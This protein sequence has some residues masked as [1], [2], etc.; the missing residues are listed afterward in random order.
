MPTGSWTFR[1]F[2]PTY[3]TGNQTPQ[4]EWGLIRAEAVFN[5]QVTDTTL[6]GTIE[7][8]GPPPGGLNLNGT[9]WPGEGDEPVSVGIIGTGRP[10]TDT[11]GWDYRYVGYLIRNWP[12]GIDQ[13]PA[14]V[15]SV[16][17]MKT[18]NGRGQSPA[19]SLYS[20][21]AVKQPPVTWELSGSWTY[22]SFE[23][24]PEPVYPTPPQQQHLIWL[25]AAFKLETPTS[26]TGLEGTLE[27][28]G[29]GLDLKGTVRWPERVDSKTVFNIVGTGRPRTDTASWEYHY[30]GLQT[31]RWPKP[32]DASKTDQVPT[33]VGSV[34]RVHGEGAP[35]GYVAPFI[36]VKK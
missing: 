8:P 20:F 36:A 35:A 26:P 11:A 34:I 31:P 24:K 12:N 2:N 21:I 13:R 30:H 10:D 7:W 1:S 5:L 15:G 17:R 27:W 25:E 32:P 23:N 6:A 18:H 16:M 19:G 28:S 4:E 22:R 29:G 3:V 9:V 33:L 14:L